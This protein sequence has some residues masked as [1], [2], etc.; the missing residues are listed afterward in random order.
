METNKSTAITLADLWNI[1][2]K[3]WWILLIAL[4]I[5]A[6]S[7]ALTSILSYRAIYATDVVY[8]IGYEGDFGNNSDLTNANNGYIVVS[9][10]LPNCITVVSQNKYYKAVADEFN[11]LPSQSQGR[12]NLTADAVKASV[13]YE[14][15][16]LTTEIH[17]RVI[18]YNAQL[19]YDIASAIAKTFPEYIKENYPLTENSSLG[20]TLINIPEVAKNPSNGRGLLGMTVGFGAGALILA[21]VVLLIIAVADDRVKSESEIADNYRVPVVANVPAFENEND[22]AVIEAFRTMSINAKFVLPQTERG[23]V[24]CVS[25]TFPS[26]GKTTVALNY[27]KACAN[28]GAKVIVVDCDLRRPQVLKVL[29]VEKSVGLGEYLSGSATYEEVLATGV[30]ENLDAIG[31]GK[32][33]PNPVVI[34][35]SRAFKE[36]IE[37]LASEYDY[38]VLDT[39]PLGV[40][41]DAL[42]LMPH[43]EGAFVIVSEGV[44][45]KKALAGVMNSIS[46]SGSEVL[47]F[48]YNGAKAK[49]KG[50]YYNYP[51]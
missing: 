23:K 22:F 14:Y 7:G 45:T 28:S 37:K 19:S 10:V 17:V 51:A 34:F 3:R 33:V 41:S 26:E 50:E 43:T 36:L 46:L 6:G 9:R 38:V 8:L 29:N 18:T 11:T 21:Y 2:I 1:F 20:C 40:V 13:T 31:C 25:S 42:T 4:V 24:V 39:P 44:C 30:A 12:I 48:V 16:E 27:A 49:K 5:G 32:I 35:N 15:T 47:G